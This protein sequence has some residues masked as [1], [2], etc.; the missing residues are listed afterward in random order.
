MSLA[1]CAAY[2]FHQPRMRV[3]E[4]VDGDA[5]RE[6]EIALARGRDQP[7]ALAPLEGEVDARE[8]RQ[9]MRRHGLAPI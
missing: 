8:G 9:E 5:R 7:G 1:A 4:R 2:R 6:V 3:A